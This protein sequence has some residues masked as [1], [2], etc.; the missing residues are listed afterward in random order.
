M[1]GAGSADDEETVIFLCEDVDG[2][3]AAFEDGGDGGFW[4]GEFFVEEL[5]RDEWILERMCK[6]FN[7]C[8]EQSSRSVS[9]RMGH[10]FDLHSRSLRFRPLC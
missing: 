2:L 3:F 7:V 8:L 5:W 1:E 6:W 9:D 10:W 4:G